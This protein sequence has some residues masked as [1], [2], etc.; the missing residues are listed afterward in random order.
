ML[1]VDTAHTN[2]ERVRRYAGLACGSVGLGDAIVEE[3]LTP[4]VNELPFAGPENRLELFRR[5]DAVLR[6]QPQGH[7]DI[8]AEFGRWQFLSPL[9]RRLVLVFP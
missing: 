2:V 8:F 5:A 3:A 4:V 9:E 1:W 6:R 7:S